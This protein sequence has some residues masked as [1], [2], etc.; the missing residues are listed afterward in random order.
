MQMHRLYPLHYPL[1][2]PSCFP[3]F[4]VTNKKGNVSVLAEQACEESKESIINNL[5]SVTQAIL[6]TV[7]LMLKSYD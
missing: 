5:A 7:C 2:S 1:Q 4:V 6:G 3:G